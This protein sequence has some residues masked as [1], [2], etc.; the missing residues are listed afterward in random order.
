MAEDAPDLD[1]VAPATE[2]SSRWRWLRRGIGVVALLAGVLALGGYLLDSDA[3][4]RLVA[5]QVAG[6]ETKAGLHIRIG[7]IDGSIYRRAVLRDVEILDTRRVFFS[8]PVVRLDWRPFAWIANRLDIRDLVIERGRLHA[9]PQLRPGDP[10]APV[11]PGFDIRIDRLR[12]EGLTIDKGVAGPRRSGRIVGKLDI[13]SG[14]ALVKI[15]AAIKGDSDRVRA[16]I[17]VVPDQNRLMLEG[18]LHAASGGVIAALVGLDKTLDASLR[19][20]GDWDLWQG[21]FEARLGE[22]RFAALNLQAHRG[23]ADIS[24]TVQAAPLGRPDLARW[25]GP[26]VALDASGSLD[27]RVLSGQLAA[28][29]A[30]LSLTAKGA[31]DLGRNRFDKLDLFARPARAESQIAGVSVRGGQAQLLLDGPFGSWTGDYRIKADRIAQG[32]FVVQ[33]VLAEGKAAARD[34]AVE[35]PLR[36]AARQIV[37]GDDYGDRLVAGLRATG[38]VRWRDGQVSSSPIRIE[39]RLAKALVQ[40]SGATARGRY[41]ANI[42][43]AVAGLGLDNLGS[44]GGRGNARIAFG[45]ALAW[46]AGGDFALRLGAVENRTLVTLVGPD[47]RL[48]GRFDYG[49][50]MPFIVRDATLAAEKLALLGGGR[51]E[52]DGAIIAR[53]SG[54]HSRY[55]PVDIWLDSRAGDTRANVALADPLPALGVKDLQLALGTVED[56]FSVDVSARSNLGPIEGQSRIYAVEDGRTRIAIDRLMVSDT[57]I[58]GDLF[59][60]PGGLSGNLAAKGGGLDGTIRFTP[61]ADGQAVDGR[62]EV[63]SARFSG[64]VPIAINRGTAN[65]AALFAQG[66][67]SIQADLS[68]QGVS[69]GSL[70][71]GRIDAKAALVDG[72]GKVTASIA[73]R[74]GSDFTLDTQASIAPQRIAISADGRYAQRRIGL[75]QPLVMTAIAGDDGVSG[76]WRVAPATLRLGRGRIGLEGR[77]G[78]ALSDVALRLDQVPLALA[79]IV[80]TDSGLGGAMSGQFTWRQPRGGL[81]TGKASLKIARLTRSGL[82]LDSRPVDLAVNLA[83]TNDA[84]SGRGLINE[85]GKAAGR[86]QARI[87]NLPAGFDL[88]GRLRRGALAGQLRYNG[89]ADSLWRLTGVEAFDITGAIGVSLDARGTLADPDV[90]GA[91]ATRAARLES[92][93]AGTIVENI[94]ARGRFEGARLY[95]TR[96]EGDAGKGGRV[97]GSGMIDYSRLFDEAPTRGVAIDIKVDADNALLV[98]RDDFAAAMTGPLTVTSNGQGGVLGGSVTITRGKFVLG[99]ADP[100]EQL[101]TIRINEINRR[102]DEAPRRSRK[103]PWR[104]DI[105]AK[106]NNRITVTG[107]GL[108]SEWSADLALGGTV[109]QPQLQGIARLVRGEFE[110]AGRRFDLERGTITF[111]NNSPPDPTLEILANADLS[112]LS[113][114]INVRGTGLKPEI[115]FSS[116]PAMPEDELLARLLFGASIN[117]ISAPEAIQ[118]ASALAALRSGGGLDPINALRGAVGL[119]RLRII[120]ADASTGQGTSIAAGKYITRNAY[121]EVITDGRGYSATQVEFQIT[122]WLS[123][124]STISTAGRQSANVR[125]SKDY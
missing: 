33:G 18:E 4:R 11:L 95:L 94:V 37:T 102:A 6:L 110:F 50:G 56:G 43:W 117:Q 100:A 112:G 83:L 122:R 44:L 57:R 31:V 10:D 55:G 115:T 42:D 34:G 32:A 89:P 3:G 72:T 35:V 22:Q 41:L 125:I 21:A 114:M 77:F 120:G 30:M 108:D 84:L 66:S 99:R 96:F 36:I 105:K 85:N 73:G 98:N 107:L 23:D 53:A 64:D 13:R 81:P 82:I 92:P 90:R 20:R 7:R 65:I 25:I 54:R 104:Y 24:G 67:T 70:F 91:L 12:A 61:R 121:V 16:N 86:F 69:A 109:D 38:D 29:S 119:D 39:S 47:P 124:L 5:E 48:S 118:L 80:L 49:K 60:I 87:A 28:R 111:Q 51:I 14:R 79:D 103:K 93:V 116:V 2:Q 88:G 113:A 46:Q 1:T 27:K 15:D 106:A 9:L 68:V 59:A 19:G 71:L 78:G 26:S 123:I 17:D 76:G 75:L 63:V 52:S 8:A 40:L 45:G 97:S 101:P 74:R 58:S 62:A